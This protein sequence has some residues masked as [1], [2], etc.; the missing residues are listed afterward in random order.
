[1]KGIVVYY[2]QTGNTKKIAQAIHT[3]MSETMEQCD[4]TRLQDIDTEGLVKYDLIGLGSP[5][6]H[7]REPI[8]VMNFI[9][10]TI[11]S[12]EGKYGFA[13]CTHGVQPGRFLARVVPIMTQRGLTVIGWNNWYCSV[14]MPE[15]P[16][17]YFT[18][19]HPDEIDLEEAERFGREMAD[20]SRRIYTGED[21]LIP[22]LPGGREYDEI[23]PGSGTTGLSGGGHP[24]AGQKDSQRSEFAVLRNF[25]FKVNR[26]KCLYPKCK[27]CIDN[28]P[29]NSINLSVSPPIFAKNCDRCWFCE[30]ICPRGAIEVDWRPMAEF[31]DENIFQNFARLA[32]EAEVKGTFRRLVPLKDVG[33]HTYWYTVKKPP[34]I[35][36]L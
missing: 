28:C 13:F 12:M 27:I 20:R 25:D 23:Y 35:K 21:D 9:E 34:R 3:G 2:S 18:D 30:Q 7:R 5:V 14:T 26:D 22:T 16:K 36:L 11:N 15:K 17:P 29:L 6:W 8:H 31:I 24:P 32:E 4:I 19:G 10:S 1:M 33:R